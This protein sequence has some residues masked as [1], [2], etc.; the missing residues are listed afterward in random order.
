MRVL[1]LCFFF[2]HGSLPTGKGGELFSPRKLHKKLQGVV[3]IR[4]K[5]TP[6][7]N[8]QQLFFGHANYPYIVEIRSLWK[9]IP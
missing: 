1:G 3:N 8:T 9:Q 5:T 4:D 2:N 7:T 6:V